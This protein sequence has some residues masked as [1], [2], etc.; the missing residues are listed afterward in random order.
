[1]KQLRQRRILH[2][3]DDPLLIDAVDEDGNVYLCERMPDLASGAQFLAVQVTGDEMRRFEDREECLRQTLLAGGRRG[4]YV[5]VPQSDFREPF[6]IKAQ[7]SSL[8]DSAFLPRAGIM[9]QG[10]WGDAP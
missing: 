4:W 9:Y 2:Y 10:A 6:S 8:S 5:S 7:R 1:M 3:H